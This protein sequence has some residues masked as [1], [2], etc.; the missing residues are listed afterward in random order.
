ME[1]ITESQEDISKRLEELSKKFADSFSDF[2]D[3]EGV[4][5]RGHILVEQSLSQAI[6]KTILYRKEYKPDRF[7]FAQKLC[8]ANMLG[9]S[10]IL[11]HELNWLNSLRN[12]IAHSLNY[13]EENVVKIIESVKTKCPDWEEDL[14][15][16]MGLRKAISFICGAIAVSHTHARLT[17]LGNTLRDLNPK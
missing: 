13:E 12:Q 4:I 5:I 8:I 11:K 14:P 10:N 16:N 1:Y 3:I 7:T 2:T 15:T 17:N 9:I 6:E